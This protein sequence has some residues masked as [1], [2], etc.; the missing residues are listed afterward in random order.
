MA[1]TAISTEEIV[2]H[3]KK[4]HALLKEAQYEF[5][6]AATMLENAVDK[7]RR[8]GVS[9]GLHELVQMGMS[10]SMCQLRNQADD[11][12]KSARTYMK[13]IRELDL[14]S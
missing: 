14:G 4:A 13:T 9:L 1:Q 3:V 12:A 11:A 2:A 10:G 6:E 8:A 5:Q 7:K